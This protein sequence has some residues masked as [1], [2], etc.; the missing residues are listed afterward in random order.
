MDQLTRTWHTYKATGHQ[1]DRDHLIGNYLPLVR[2]VANQVANTL[3]INITRDD[4]VSPG[5][6]GLID[7]IEKYDLDR[8]IKFETYAVPRIK[9][10][11]LDE[12]RANDWVPR[13]VRAK[14]RAIDQ[15]VTDLETELHRNP[16][17]REVAR[18]LG[19]TV[20]QLRATHTQIALAGV[21]ALDDPLSPDEPLTVGDTI[22]HVDHEPIN[23]IT[24]LG[25]TIAR[26]I[27][28]IPERERMVP[29]LYYIAGLTLAEIGHVLGVNE[30]RVCQMHTKVVRRLRDALITRETATG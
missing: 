23:D 27:A 30:S 12:L 21:V 10:A 3:P 6:F 17:D 8:G 18:E 24:D 4:L 22:A 14:A 29:A 11:I 25:A 20:T 16:T 2:Y 1:R 13:S 19:S 15:A 7:A 26:L 28:D 9:G 5:S